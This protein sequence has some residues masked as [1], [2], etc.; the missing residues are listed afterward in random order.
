M[1]VFTPITEVP[2]KIT[3]GTLVE[4]TNSLISLVIYCIIIIVIITLL[5]SYYY[6][7]IYFYFI[8]YFIF[9]LRLFVLFEIYNSLLFTRKLVAIKT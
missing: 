8:L 4:T 3:H 5:R 6:L 2:S 1:F 7:Y 9:E